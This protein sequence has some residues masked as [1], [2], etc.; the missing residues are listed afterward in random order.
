[1]V[2]MIMVV[3]VVVVL[4]GVVCGGGKV[5][6]VVD[7]G[8]GVDVL[9]HVLIGIVVIVLVAVLADGRIGTV[10]REGPMVVRDTH[11]VA[12]CLR[13]YPARTGRPAWAEVGSGGGAWSVGLGRC[14]DKCAR[15]GSRD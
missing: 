8:F 2:V 15:E 14:D 10:D 9:V 3:M 11:G 1:M 12:D 5:G 7:I 4:V 6:H 13:A